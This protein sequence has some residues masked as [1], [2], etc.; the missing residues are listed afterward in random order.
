MAVIDT[1]SRACGRADQNDSA[2]MTMI[3]GALQRMAL[4]HHAAILL[5]DHHRKSAR[6]S[7]DTD[8][9]D[10][11]IG[12]TAKAGVVDCALGLYRRHNEAEGLLKLSGRDFG[13]AEIPL[14]WDADSFTWQ[15]RE[16]S[17]TT[18]PAGTPGAAARF[19]ERDYVT[20]TAVE[21]LGPATLTQLVTATGEA[22]GNLY[23]RLAA[24]C[25]REALIRQRLRQRHPLLPPPPGVRPGFRFRHSIPR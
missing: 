7:P 12:S 13:D 1:F 3:M 22:K 23:N 4:D 14:T 6:T 18:A 20:L 9:I 16:G 15:L 2:D 17:A 5:V 19:T 21:D 11:I 25:R 8:P 10:D 24:L